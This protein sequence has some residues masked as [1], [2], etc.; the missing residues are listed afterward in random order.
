MRVIPRH[1]GLNESLPR[2][3]RWKRARIPTRRRIP[4]LHRP[5]ERPVVRPSARVSVAQLA[6]TIGV[7]LVI[8]GAG[9]LFQTYFAGRIYPHVTI[10]HVPVGG[11]TRD[12]ALAALQDTETARVNEPIYAQAQE[13]TWRV[14][15]AQFGAR[16]DVAAAVDRALAFK[17]TG[18]FIFGGW[19]EAQAIA[20]GANL[21]LSGTHDPGSI[22][23]FVASIAGQVHIA[24]RR[25]VVGVRGDDAVIVHEP[26]PGRRLDIGGAV[27][28]LSATVN[29]HDATQVALPVQRVDSALGHAQA[30]AAVDHARKLLAAPVIFELPSQRQSWKLDRQAMARLLTFT[31]ECTRR[32]CSFVMGINAR[33]LSGAF[34]H[35]GVP[36]KAN[37]EPQPATYALNFDSFSSQPQL[38]TYQDTVGQSIDVEKAAQL[39]LQQADA[40]PGARR[41]VQLPMRP[42]LASFTYQDAQKLDFNQAIGSSALSFG[43]LDNARVADMTLATSAISN[44][45]VM[46]GA[47]FDLAKVAGP[48]S[49]GYVAGLNVVNGSDVTGANG[50][51]NIAG[52]VV[53]RAAYDSGLPIVRRDHYP[54]LNAFAPLGLDTEISYGKGSP[55]L[56]FSNTTDHQIL[57]MSQVT[58]RSD[59]TR[60]VSVYIFNSAG[61]APE[62]KQGSYSSTVGSPQVTINPDGS[63]QASIP[64]DLT[65]AGHTTHDTLDDGSAPIDP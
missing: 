18:P 14:T 23:R 34:V 48:F 40:P 15:P 61:F 22:R 51:V 36:E 2:R 47:T 6:A 32:N 52:S 57:V 5:A 19:G 63:V 55:D 29:T 16:Y 53:L 25:A 11:M 59:G 38:I 1:R 62:H 28:T 65:I 17:H 46:P 33:L 44:T 31:P 41:E 35:G 58:T 42:W 7:A 50:G 26:V 60:D 13:K 3:L 4:K 43:G 54:Y 56:T 20:L 64:R 12:K 39:V 10:D 9:A 24:P 21:P 8:W 37:I 45:R 49:T 27:A 30:Q